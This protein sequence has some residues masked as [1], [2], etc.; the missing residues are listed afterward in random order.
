MNKKQA[1]EVGEHYISRGEECSVQTQATCN[2]D[3]ANCQNW[4]VKVTYPN[5]K[6][7]TVTDYDQFRKENPE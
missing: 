2:V 7:Q 5:G 3:P 4:Y 6:S 1:Q